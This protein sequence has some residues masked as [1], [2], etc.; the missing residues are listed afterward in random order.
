MRITWTSVGEVFPLSTEDFWPILINCVKN[1]L[2]L[3]M[4][5][6]L[7]YLCDQERS[8][9]GSMLLIKPIGQGS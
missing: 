9:A 4:A 5:R 2:T 6:M 1:Y 3:F 7:F 8:Q